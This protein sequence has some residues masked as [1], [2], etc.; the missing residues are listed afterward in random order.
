M[1]FPFFF[2][3]SSSVYFETFLHVYTYNLRNSPI[4]K[5]YHLSSVPSKPRITHLTERKGTSVVVHWE[6]PQQVNGKLIEYELRWSL[7]SGNGQKSTPRLISGHL[8]NRMTATIDKLSKNNHR[9][10][11]LSKPSW[12]VILSAF[13]FYFLLQLC[14]LTSMLFAPLSE[15]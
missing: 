8:V 1:R 5:F 3:C 10:T 7:K 6:P 4:L 2:F 15:L 12:S 13:S 9:I 11:N 14:L